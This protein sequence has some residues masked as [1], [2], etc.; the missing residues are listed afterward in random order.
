MLKTR[1]IISRVCLVLSLFAVFYGTVFAAPEDEPLLLLESYSIVSGDI[2]DDEM[3]TL[4]Y[5]L[6]NTSQSNTL[7]NIVMSFSGDYDVFI[8]EDGKPNTQYIGSVSAGG[9][10]T[11]YLTLK[12]DSE[13]QEGYYSLVFRLNYHSETQFNLSTTSKIYLYVNNRNEI[14]IS[15]I[16]L[17]DGCYI[18]QNVT[19]SAY[20]EN[21]GTKEI[22]N[23]VLNVSGDILENQK[24]LN[25]GDIAA[26][27]TTFIDH[28]IQFTSLGVQEITIWFTYEDESGIKY[29][30][31]HYN[32]NILVTQQEEVTYQP[33]AEG[34]KIDDQGV[35]V[36]ITENIVLISAALGIVVIVAVVLLLR[37]RKKKK[38]T[39]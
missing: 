6:V 33:D 1:K 16:E 29:E 30:T 8:P 13:A 28:Q 20:Y 23:I 36:S 34:Q 24:A 21:F 37:R 11:G 5:T 35:F 17:T 12:A 31:E 7:S 32:K 2:I 3:F 18:N 25:V 10:Y 38:R 22:K 19:I 4:E 9:T 15:K 39:Y 26:K 14:S 27:K